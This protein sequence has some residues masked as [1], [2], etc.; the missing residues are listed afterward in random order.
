MEL[1]IGKTFTLERNF[2]NEFAD[3][4][5][6]RDF[7][8]TAIT[9]KAVGL[10]NIRTGMPFTLSMPKF[11]SG[12]DNTTRS[13]MPIN[14]PRVK[15]KPKTAIIVPEL[16]KSTVIT[17]SAVV[18]NTAPITPPNT[19]EDTNEDTTVKEEAKPD[20]LDSVFDPFADL[21]GD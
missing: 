4:R 14:R 16:P 10:V 5:T 21:Y 9:D 18:L 19:T 20:N 13:V 2:V 12:V 8:I 7:R 15:S 3:S 11:T 17:P 6:T 1:I